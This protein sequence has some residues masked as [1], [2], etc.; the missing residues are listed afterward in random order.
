MT[1][2]RWIEAL[3]AQDMTA[4]EIADFIWLVN[5]W[6]R[7]RGEIRSQTSPSTTKQGQG[8]NQKRDRKESGESPQVKGQ[9]KERQQSQ[10]K[11]QGGLFPN[12]RSRNPNLPAP[13]SIPVKVRKPPALRR[14]LDLM[15]SLRPL[16]RQ[17][18]ARG[19]G[20]LDELKT[21]QKISDE[22]IWLPAIAPRLEPWLELALVI[23]ESSSMLLW[24]RTVLELQRSLKNYGAFRDVRTWGMVLAKQS[25]GRSSTAQP[26]DNDQPSYQVHLR[27]WVGGS[28]ASQMLRKPAELIDPTGRRLILVVSDCVSTIWRQGQVLPALETWADNSPTAILQMLP[29]WLW[30]RTAL[31]YSSPAQLFG[32]EPGMANQCLS[33]EQQ[34]LPD[35]LDD[36]KRPRQQ[37]RMPILTLDLRSTAIWS[38]M[39]AGRG[40]VRCPGFIF[41]PDLQPE[42]DR[43]EQRRQQSRQASP[44]SPDEQVKRFMRAASSIARRLIELLAAAPIVNLPVVQLIQE[45]FLKESTQV[46]V[47]EVLLGG[48]LRPAAPPTA[49]THA[50]EVIY[51]FISEEIRPILLRT[52][53]VVDTT[54]V[55]SSYVLREFGTSLE[56]FIFHF[57]ELPAGDSAQVDAVKPIAIVAAEVLKRWGRLYAEFVSEV[58]QRYDTQIQPVVPPPTPLPP[59]R[60]LQW[61]KF[62]IGLLVPEGSTPAKALISIELTVA[63]LTVEGIA[64]EAEDALEPFEF[65]TVTV[66]RTGHGIERRQLQVWQF[67]ERLVPL[68]DS[69]NP[70][71]EDVPLEMVSIP[72]GIFLMGSDDKDEHGYS[73]ERPQHEVTI[74]PFFISKHPITQSQWRI[75]ASLEIIEQELKPDPSHFK[76]DDRPV[77]QVSWHDAMEFCARLSRMTGREYRLPSEAEWEYAC[78]ANTTTPFAFGETLT[79]KLANYNASN[80]FAEEPKGE[81]RGETTPVGNFYAN[82]FGLSD[83]HGNVWEWCLDHWHKTYEGAPTDGSAWVT[84]GGKG[85]RI[86]RGGSWIHYPRNCR[87]ACRDRFDPGDGYGSLGFRVVCVAPRTY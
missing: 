80:L 70:S 61:M 66:D 50:D 5:Q 33:A 78:R 45:T 10:G 69:I 64:E 67:T 30:V 65:E 56:A 11:A 63:T 59:R 75:I 86:V 27:A 68:A 55:L 74:E 14:S 19:K 23:D 82:A 7:D 16:M 8:K 24:R 26:A 52:A 81:S 42:I 28:S 29:D 34:T 13:P 48:L 46:H 84:G 79:A 73:D 15:R 76:G 12:Q 77:E 25:S 47:A 51:C 9:S 4:E 83:M 6:Q 62:D 40:G 53:S 3:S 17:M 38:Q 31:R 20:K 37:I 35:D 57:R 1:I 39:V 87:S 36:R 21:A 58:E 54:E 32:L 43:V 2:D 72:G 49:N 22:R 44:P 60:Q 18:P 41:R 71:S 85:S